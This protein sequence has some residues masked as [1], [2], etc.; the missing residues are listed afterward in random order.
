ML[1]RM[2]MSF[3]TEVSGPTITDIPSGA[4]IF[5]QIEGWA[6]RSPSQVAFIVDHQEKI[7]EYRYADVIEQTERF[8]ATLVARGV[9]QGD[10]VGILMENIPQWVFALLGAMRIGA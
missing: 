2:T 5:E 4:W 6:K 7:E 3:L 10:R 1:T 8:A 9:R